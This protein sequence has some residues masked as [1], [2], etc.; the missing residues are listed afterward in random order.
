MSFVSVAVAHMWSHVA[1]TSGI[2][3]LGR[4]ALD[5][6]LDLIERHAATFT[7]VPSPVIPDATAALAG[8]PR[9]LAALRNINVGAS[10]IPEQVLAAFADVVGERVVGVYGLTEATG[11]PLFAARPADWRRPSVGFARVG[12]IVAPAVIRLVGDDGV[13]QPWDG[14]AVGEIVA[15]SPAM[16]RGYWRDEAAT[17]ATLRSGWLH[18]GDLGSITPDGY[19]EHPG[20]REGHAR[21]GRDQRV[22]GGDRGS[23][24]GGRGDRGVRGGRGSGRALG[25]AADRV[26]DA[27]RRSRGRRR[28]CPCA[29]R[30]AMPAWRASNAP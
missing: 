22:P 27:R 29:R 10:P 4:Y 2:V 11:V 3:L 6:Q 26:R 17:A 5:R 9:A 15:A 23:C 12:A 28:R 24:P 20:P 18:T 25:R 21:V 19:L 30:C 13:D 8:A 16:M 1:L 14:T 7:Y